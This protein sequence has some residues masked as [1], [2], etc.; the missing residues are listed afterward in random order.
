MPTAPRL[1][2]SLALV[3]AALSAC[4]PSSTAN[5][6]QGAGGGAGGAGG[7]S[8]GT[9]DD[10]GF[11]P[12]TS[13]G[14]GS[15]GGLEGC[16]TSSEGATQIPVNMFVT[17]DKSGSMKDNQKWDNAKAAF[18][19]FF[20]DPDAASL[21]V[22]LRFWPD[23][24]CDGNTCDV[25]V[26]ASPA[27][28]VGPL[29]DAGH[30]QALVDQFNAHSPGGNT[31]MSAALG[32][33]TKWASSYVGQVES[34]EKAVVVLVTDGEP[35]GCDNDV[36]HIAQEAKD[37]YDAAGVQ[38]FAV[39]LAG[40][41]QATMDQIAQGGSTGQ[42]FFI[43]NGNAK[44]DLIAALKK[45]QASSVA[46]V[47]AMPKAEAGKVIDPKLINVNYT[48]GAGPE[49]TLGQVPDAGAC[50]AKG[51]WFYDDPSKPS[52][53]KLCPTTCDTVQGDPGAKMAIVLGC[54]TTPG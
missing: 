53:I 15:S 5:E 9:G 7:H 34:S 45:I 32:G 37:A 46:C 51:G 44:A 31:P 36:G 10:L 49:Q 35:N 24:G 8:S 21:R 41:N 18:L 19:A 20:Q 12:S 2:A 22:A 14:S 28:D 43:G 38:T 40:S 47:Y 33:A 11:N 48:P 16:A 17:V 27:V 4:A 54:A 50:G 13:S 26:C 52:I 6:L 29:S 30:V 3:S 23:S 25:D 39:G 1:L 42:G